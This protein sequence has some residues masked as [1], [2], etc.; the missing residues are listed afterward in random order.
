MSVFF[1]NY[2]AETQKLVLTSEKEN[3]PDGCKYLEVP[4]YSDSL[5][6]DDQA[7]YS[8]I[9]HCTFDD[10]TNPT[11]VVVNFSAVMT[12]IKEGLREFR[13]RPLLAL[14]VMQQR[15]MVKNNTT[16]VNEIEAD[17]QLLR[18]CINNIDVTKFTKGSDFRKYIPD[19]LFIDYVAKYKSKV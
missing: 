9:E 3:I 18:D 13:V 7:K 8:Y 2:P 1:Y 16:V 10:Y 15:A 5:S 12:S 17:K 19:V 6:L 14:D 4:D 11:K